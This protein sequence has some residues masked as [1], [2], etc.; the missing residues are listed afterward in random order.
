MLTKADRRYK[1]YNNNYTFVIVTNVTITNVIKHGCILLIM[2][3]KTLS[4]LIIKDEDTEKQVK[5]TVV[6]AWKKHPRPKP[7]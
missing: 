5:K 3:S 2:K 6:L 4:F 1:V 7:P